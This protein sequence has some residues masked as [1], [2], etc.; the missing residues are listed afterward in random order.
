MR[1][2]LFLDRKVLS[3][4]LYDWANSAFATTIVAGF[5]PVL[6]SHM[7]RDLSTQ[8]A[9]IWLNIT[10]AIG[11]IVVGISSPILG[12]IADSGNQRKTFLAGFTL[13]GIIMCLG[14]GW[15]ASGVWWMALILY[16]IGLIGFNGAITFYNSLLVMVSSIDQVDIVSGFGYALGY[17]GGGLLFLINVLMVTNPGWFGLASTSVALAVSFV[18]VGIWWLLFSLPLFLFVKEPSAVQKRSIGS[19]AREGWY[20]FKSTFREIRVLRAASFFLIGY[21]LYI[22]GVATIFKMA[23]FFADRILGLP[24]ESLIKALLLTQ[25]VAFPAALFFGWFGKKIGPKSGIYI[26]I[27]VYA[28]VI[29]YAWQWLRSA[30]D[31]YFLAAS[32]GL[33][34]GGIQG[35][36]RSLFARLIPKS[37]VAEFFGFFNLVGR[38]SSILGP[39]LMIIV[40]LAI[41]GADE[42]DSILA[43]LILFAGG[44]IF[45]SKVD[46]A[47]GVVEANQ[48]DESVIHS[49]K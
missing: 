42:R 5:F 29:T 9:Q 24:S 14:L 44:A 17:I 37:K 25:F 27:V 48:L 36:S 31:F 11:S 8:D 41:I 32:I 35:L 28:V 15:A 34:Q 39:L 21:W 3:W 7:T 12:A 23:V 46:I 43:L 13:L 18:S 49:K 33:V 47:S 30:M 10:I 6:Y 2:F 45:L 26:C 4:A 38:F 19:T 40:P 22:D 16:G 20:R 1:A